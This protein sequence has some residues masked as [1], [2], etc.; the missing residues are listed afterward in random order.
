MTAFHPDRDHEGSL[1]INLTA[2]ENRSAQ[3]IRPHRLLHVSWQDA[4][5]RSHSLE[6]ADIHDFLDRNVSYTVLREGTMLVGE[7]PAVY[8][9]VSYFRAHAPTVVFRG[10][11]VR[12]VSDH[13]QYDFRFSMRYN[14]EYNILLPAVMRIIESARFYDLG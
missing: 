6:P 3:S 11:M 5:R 13:S 2:D 10:M 7:M 1:I 14:G 4:N 9:E 12:V 8:M